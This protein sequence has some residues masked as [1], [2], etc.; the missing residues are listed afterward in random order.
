ML[1]LLVKMKVNVD[2]FLVCSIANRSAYSSALEML[3]YLG[4]LVA[5]DT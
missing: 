3:G 5:I 2:R 1:R 4:N